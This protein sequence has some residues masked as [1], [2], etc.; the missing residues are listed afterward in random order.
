MVLDYC[1]KN[2]IQQYVND[3][4]DLKVSKNAYS[5]INERVERLIDDAVLRAIENDRNTVMIR[6]L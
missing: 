2:K 4:K 6:D 5:K 1:K 3:E